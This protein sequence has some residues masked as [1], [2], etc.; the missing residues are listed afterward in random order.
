MLTV[1]FILKIILE[2]ITSLKHGRR[3]SLLL[4]KQIRTIL[5]NHNCHNWSFGEQ[6]ILLVA[7][8]NQ[9]KVNIF[10]I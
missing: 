7:S 1:I 5:C 4:S 6:Y 2:S 8:F 10:E 3:I 9:A